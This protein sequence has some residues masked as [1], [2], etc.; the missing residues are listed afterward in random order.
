MSDEETRRAERR[1]EKMRAAR[2]RRRAKKNQ[3][4]RGERM[5]VGSPS[6]RPKPLLH[7]GI[8]AFSAH[9]QQEAARGRRRSSGGRQGP[10][11]C[12]GSGRH[13]ATLVDGS[14]TA[15]D[16]GLL[17]IALDAMKAKGNE[18]R[19]G[20]TGEK[21]AAE[22]NAAYVRHP[23]SVHVTARLDGPGRG[24]ERGALRCSGAAR[25]EVHFR[26]ASTT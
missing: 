19:R 9:W 13:W 5:G 22:T 24:D 20:S 7:Q 2:G 14:L 8:P 25:Y 12:R 17:A 21:A 10:R 3:G 23:G 15:L 11:L 6:Q 4:I 1:A 26:G 18:V 16:A